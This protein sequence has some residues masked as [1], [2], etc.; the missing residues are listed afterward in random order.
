MNLFF[1]T[2]VCIAHAYLLA[3]PGIMVTD[4]CES[5]YVCVVEVINPESPARTPRAMPPT[6]V[7]S[8]LYAIIYLLQSE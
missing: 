1:C 2:Q 3:T 5:P 7:V 6:P 4:D 8:F